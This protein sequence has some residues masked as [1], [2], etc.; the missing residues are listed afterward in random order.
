MFKI[1]YGS[2]NPFEGI[3]PTPMVERNIS[4]IYAAKKQGEMESYI[5]K[6]V[7][8]GS[9]CQQANEFSG[10]YTKANQLISNFSTPFQR[11]KIVE[12]NGAGESALFSNGHAIVRSVDFD[13]SVYAGILPFTVSLDVYS[14]ESFA[15]Y[16]ILDPSQQIAFDQKEN[17]DV[18]ISK[19][20]KANGFNT[21]TPAFENAVSFVQG[22]TGLNPYFLPTFIPSSGIDKAILSTFDEKINRL[23][24]SYEVSEG[25]IYNH[26]GNYGNHSLYEKVVSIDSGD[27]VVT[28]S[29]NGKLTGGVKSSFSDLRADFNDI[30]FFAIADEI[31]NQ[32]A[33]GELFVKPTSKQISEDSL[34][35]TISFG[36]TYSDVIK[37]DPYVIDSLVVSY[38]SQT[39]KNCIQ[40]SINIKSSDLCPS[41]RWRK[42]K[43]YSDNFA[44]IPWIKNKLSGLGYTLNLPNRASSSSY[45]YNEKAGAI[46]ISASVC[47]KKIIIP[48]LFDDITYSV[49][50]VPSMPTFVPFQGLDGRGE[51]TVQMLG[52]LTRKTLTIQG[53]AQMSECSTVESSKISLLS[54]IN[55]VKDTY[56]EGSDKYLSQKNIVQGVGDARN[57]LNFSFSWNEKSDVIFNNSALL[58]SSLT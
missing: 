4:S 56:L 36:F 13:D 18:S 29:I 5:L 50:I 51:C 55:N 24:G 38:D 14:Q 49:S 46:S 32:N 3:S 10:F 25:W 33:F 34:S 54:Y 20:T 11:F 12:D 48:A 57:K 37:E 30:D 1:I 45:S 39:N 44:I 41:E 17:G 8:T 52:G 27:G 28:V 7:I 23:E 43:N 42:V 15:N 19:V 26:Y 35:K 31:Y 40:G 9:H 6:G 21:N 47:E 22:I 58:H 16:G 2:G 53:S